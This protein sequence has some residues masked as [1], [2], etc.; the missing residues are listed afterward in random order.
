MRRWLA[1]LLLFA[2]CDDDTLQTSHGDLSAEPRILDFGAVPEGMA[3]TQAVV[4]TNP[5]SLPIL[6]TAAMKDGSA[7]DFSLRAMSIQLSPRE[8]AS[9]EIT[10]SPTGAGVDHGTVV[11]TADDEVIA[12]VEITLEGG[13]ITGRL[14]ATPHPLELAPTS[15]ATSTKTLQLSNGGNANLTITAVGIGTDANPDFDFVQPSL[16]L[17]LAPGGGAR[18]AM[19]Y[20]RSS[21]TDAGILVVRSDAGDVEVRLVPDALAA[22]EDGDDNDGDGL[23]DFPQDPGCDQSRDDDEFN[24]PECETGTVAACGSSTG[25]CRQG[26]RHC[27]NSLWGPC[28]GAVGPTDE[29]CDGV[30]NDCDNRVDEEI[31]ETCAIHGCA[32]SRTCVESST[33]PT[34]LWTGCGPLAATTETCDGMDNDCNGTIDDGIT[35]VCVINGCA[36]TQACLPGGTG[37]LTECRPSNATGEVCNGFDDDCNGVPDDG[38]G[39][40]SCGQ[41]VC[42]ATAAA[43][44]SG[45][46]GP[47]PPGPRG[48]EACN[49]MD[50]DCNGFDDDGLGEITCGQGVCTATAAACVGGMMGV[51]TPGPRGTE[52]C[53]GMDDD[54]NGFDDDGLGVL[55][56]GRGACTATAAACANGML[57]VCTPGTGTDE[58]C[59]NFDDDC[60]G[61]D[62]DGLITLDAPIDS[63]SV[64]SFAPRL[65]WTAPVA[66]HDYTV[67]LW[68]P[69]ATPHASYP[70]AGTSPHTVGPRLAVAGTY[71]W[72]VDGVRSDNGCTFS[73]TV[74]MFIT[75]PCGYSVA[76]AQP[77]PGATVTA[78]PQLGWNAGLGDNCA[79]SIADDAGN[80]LAGYPR[81]ASSPHS[82]S[83]P[84]ASGTYRWWID[85]TEL[86]TGCQAH[87]PTGMPGYRTFTVPQSCSL[88]APALSQ[89]AD[90]VEW[91]G[92]PRLVWAT[93]TGAVDYT[94]QVDDDIGFTSPTDFTTAINEAH[95]VNDINMSL[96]APATYYWRARANDAGCNGPWSTS[97][98]FTVRTLY[99]RS[100]CSGATQSSRVALM[101]GGILGFSFAGQ[102]EYVT[103]GPLA[104]KLIIPITDSDGLFTVASQ[105]RCFEASGL[106]PC[107]T[108]PGSVFGQNLATDFNT[109]VPGATVDEAGR[110]YV[111]AS[112]ALTRRLYQYDSNGSASGSVVTSPFLGGLAYDPG[113][114]APQI[115]SQGN[116]STTIYSV[117]TAGATNWTVAASALVNLDIEYDRARDRIFQTVQG[118]VVDVFA[119]A[120]ASG[121]APA[122]LFSVTSLQPR[123][124]FGDPVG[125]SGYLGPASNPNFIAVAD[126]SDPGGLVF[127]F[128]GPGAADSYPVFKVSDAALRY[129]VGMDA[130]PATGDLYVI[131]H[132]TGTNLRFTAFE[133][134]RFCPTP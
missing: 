113:G 2:G 100:N 87:A 76:L 54:C 50:D 25:A 65:S 67:H 93:Q 95:V 69:P 108:G 46:A 68:Q 91:L 80:T 122:R 83:T 51:C 121:P 1:V 115:L 12:P 45:M 131:T 99:D 38:L 47:C 125:L 56:C 130:D 127:L 21:R 94:V 36:G 73:S 60:N 64:N 104:N 59:N 5:G 84:L 31:V 92:G 81:T 57:G 119:Y 18:I 103:N 17:T 15:A 89:P 41:G 74:A 72:R 112:D 134:L 11:L 16:P 133:V 123:L 66:G 26:E 13:P 88:T 35:V 28:E 129:S 53:N 101:G 132:P 3:S 111:S 37:M 128:V 9:L 22:C 105:M 58:V 23:I 97:R 27:R 71:Q 43:C 118:G 126:Y 98:S 114:G 10:F 110:I 24:V 6:V 20:F 32:G 52:V 33:V 14:D 55:T 19:R 82:P 116:G 42:T 29:L 70:R 117:S 48:T 106:T 8:I 40:I 49:G 30:D 96:T 120:G 7:A 62:D 85:C 79:V 77:A 102:L 61:L 34:G 90:G 44:V 75:D 63:A 107:T 124:T 39:E 86:G 78:Q 4:L 109:N